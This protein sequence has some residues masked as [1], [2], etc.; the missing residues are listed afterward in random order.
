M[1]HALATILLLSASYALAA[2]P[3]VTG[4]DKVYGEV[5]DWVE[6]KVATT[7][8]SVKFVP[9]SPALKVFPPDK[10]KDPLS[11]MVRAGE[12]NTYQLLAY[13]G[14][15]DGPSDPLVI[16]VTFGPPQ[17]G[18]NP[19]TPPVPPVPPPG[20]GVDPATLKALTAAYKREVA[21]DTRERTKAL[22]GAMSDAAKL[23]ADAG[24]TT[25]AVLAARVNKATTER[26]GDS[27]MELRKEIGELLKAEFPTE[28]FTLTADRRKQFSAAYTRFAL[29]LEELAR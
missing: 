7:G 26:V 2:P 21:A 11:T 16:T 14:T 23:A 22:A 20:P 19:P 25:N 15:E 8:K 4:P 9:L 5:G 27:V 28:V 12:A 18:P 24:I 1:R 13:T 17:P 29:V 10:L 6:V 3:T